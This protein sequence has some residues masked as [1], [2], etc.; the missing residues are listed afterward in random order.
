MRFGTVCKW[1]CT[2]CDAPQMVTLQ[3]T[4]KVH[5]KCTTTFERLNSA[6][7]IEESYPFTLVGVARWCIAP[8]ADVCNCRLQAELKSRI[9]QL[10]ALHDEVS[11]SCCIHFFA[12]TQLYICIQWGLAM[13]TIAIPPVAQYRRF[14][15][16]DTHTQTY[17]LPVYETQ[18]VVQ[19][20]LFL[21]AAQ[22]GGISRPYCTGRGIAAD[23]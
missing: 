8:L 19:L 9:E 14:I 5:N 12:S 20:R 1:S 21:M 17:G 6:A 13:P 3:S 18:P 4:P 15:S 23:V 10:G 11:H 16:G 22:G 2:T 7:V